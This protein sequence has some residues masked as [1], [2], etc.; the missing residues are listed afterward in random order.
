MRFKKNL[1]G[2]AEVAHPGCRVRHQLVGA[3]MNLVLG[4][5][6]QP[7]THATSGGLHKRTGTILRQTA[8]AAASAT[9]H[10][11]IKEP[12]DKIMFP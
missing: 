6:S 9:S 12:W 1:A 2:L 8:P 4:T 7:S 5:D 11:A 3:L 10:G